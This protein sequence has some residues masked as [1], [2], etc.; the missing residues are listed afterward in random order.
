MPTISTRRFAAL[1]DLAYTK[2]LPEGFLKD[3]PVEA[4]WKNNVILEWNFKS[5]SEPKIP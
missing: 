1:K 3:A 2:V 4:A 5:S